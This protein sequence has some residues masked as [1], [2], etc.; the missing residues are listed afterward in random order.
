MPSLVE[1]FDAFTDLLETGLSTNVVKG[2][3][4]IGRAGF[5]YP[6]VAVIFN[7]LDFQSIPTRPHPIGSPHP[8][9]GQASLQIALIAADEYA[10]WQLAD[11]VFTLAQAS[12]SL[13]VGGE[14][15]KAV[16]QTITRV[17]GDMDNVFNFAASTA[18]VL[19][20]RI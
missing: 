9:G 13:T 8:R 16:W 5:S 18:V 19:T 3:P 6:A 20:W 2:M 7:D 14:T 10:L 17:S 4:T 11:A 15:V 12:S 1:V